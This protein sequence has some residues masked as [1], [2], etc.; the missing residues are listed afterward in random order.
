MDGRSDFYGSGLVKNYQHMMSAQYDWKVLLRKF[1]IDGVMVKPDAP[2]ASVLK[3][4]SDWKLLFDDGSALL[5]KLEE[6]GGVT[7]L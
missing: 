2:L 5:F 4:S 3:M 6:P 1:S 7:R